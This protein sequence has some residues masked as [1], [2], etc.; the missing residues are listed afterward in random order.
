MET[1][2]CRTDPSGKGALAR[3]PLCWRSPWQKV[4]KTLP[5]REVLVTRGFFAS[6][7]MKAWLAFQ[8]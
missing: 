5:G 4:S 6:N 7:R 3:M 8:S 2:T 1:R